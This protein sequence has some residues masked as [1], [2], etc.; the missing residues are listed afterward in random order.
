MET[1]LKLLIKT[2]CAYCRVLITGVLGDHSPWKF[3]LFR[4][5][6]KGY[7]PEE[8]GGFMPIKPPN[9]NHQNFTSMF[10]VVRFIFSTLSIVQIQ[11]FK[12]NINTMHTCCLK[13][14][15]T[16]LMSTVHFRNHIQTYAY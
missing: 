4:S 12:R 15:Y 13:R 7:K 16:I 14:A 10:R 9:S 1:I 8:Q 2:N 11:Q 6:M 5:Y 3:H